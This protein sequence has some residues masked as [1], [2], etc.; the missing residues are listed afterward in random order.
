MKLVQF[1]IYTLTIFIYNV[2]TATYFV[3][4]I[5]FRQSYP[6]F[7]RGFVREYQKLSSKQMWL[8]WLH[9]KEFHQLFWSKLF[10][11]TFQLA[12]IKQNPSIITTWGNKR[13]SLLCAVQ[14]GADK[15]KIKIS[16]CHLQDVNQR[17]YAS[18]LLFRNTS[19]MTYLQ[20]VRLFVICA[21]VECH[22]L[23]K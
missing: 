21:A 15:K 3:T 9:I 1:I 19:F 8:F 20:S 2:S 6:V 17:N 4:W 7:Q 10:K 14:S 23:S 12:E 16:S 11:L 18:Y 5:T 13:Y 22:Y